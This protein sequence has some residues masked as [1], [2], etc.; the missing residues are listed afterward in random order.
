MYFLT[1]D[2]PYGWSLSSWRKIVMYMR[3][4]ATGLISKNML[5]I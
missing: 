5:F 3:P 2:N 1:I 4:A